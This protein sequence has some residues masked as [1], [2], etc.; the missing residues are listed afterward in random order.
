VVAD[1]PGIIRGA[2]KGKGLGLRFLRHIERNALLLFLIPADSNSI[3]D[4]YRILQ[5]ELSEY[6]P[7]LLDKTRMLAITKS[8]LL[9]DELKAE[10]RKE[11]PSVK[12]LFIS[13][14]SGEG[15]RKLKDMI[16]EELNKSNY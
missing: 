10:I 11:L 12:Y 13:S 6:N 5:N 3:I 9:D 14:V 1:I 15:I 2:S 7:E 4:E 8:D 16:W